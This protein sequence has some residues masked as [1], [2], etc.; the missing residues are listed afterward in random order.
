MDKDEKRVK[1]LLD[2]N[3]DAVAGDIKNPALFDTLR[4]PKVAF[5]LSNEKDSNLAAVQALKARYPT[6]R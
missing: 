4:V 3:Y 2:Q 1:D 5:V 6:P